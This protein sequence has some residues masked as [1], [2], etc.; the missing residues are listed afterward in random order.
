MRR[1]HRSEI[2]RP[3]SHGQSESTAIPLASSAATSVQLTLVLERET[4]SFTPSPMFSRSGWMFSGAGL[5]TRPTLVK[6]VKFSIPSRFS[7]AQREKKHA[8]N[9]KQCAAVHTPHRRP[10]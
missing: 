5:S 8:N 10:G 4:R 3:T 9:E 6:L 7:S 1:Q 2:H